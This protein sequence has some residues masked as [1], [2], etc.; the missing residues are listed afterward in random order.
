MHI[1]LLCYPCNG[2]Q[3]MSSSRKPSIELSPRQKFIRKNLTLL[4]IYGSFA[5]VLLWSMSRIVRR[6]E[7]ANASLQHIK[8]TMME[9]YL[10]T[11]EQ[12]QIRQECSLT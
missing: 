6:Q 1:I 3:T 11:R 8:D 4:V 2:I 5:L 10:E 7:Q 12:A 9:F